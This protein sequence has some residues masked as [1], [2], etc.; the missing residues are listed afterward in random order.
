ME[1]RSTQD[2]R[3]VNNEAKIIE[4]RSTQND[5]KIEEIVQLPNVYQTLYTVITG[6]NKK[7]NRA[8]DKDKGVHAKNQESENKKK[9]PTTDYGNKTSKLIKKITDEDEI[10]DEDVDENTESEFNLY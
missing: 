9:N 2:Q 6:K 4:M 1:M 3:Q 8:T 5:N 7:K 10:T